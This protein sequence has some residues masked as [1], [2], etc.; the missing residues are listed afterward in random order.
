MS[1]D[2]DNLDAWLREH[3]DANDDL[4][5]LPRLRELYQSAG[6]PEP[7]EADWDRLRSR[8]HK[9]IGR[10][11]APRPWWA[12]AAASVAAAIVATLLTRSLWNTTEPVPVPETVQQI[13]EPFPV[14]DADDVAIVSMDAHDV[15]ALVVGEPPVGEDL[16]FARPEDI[17]VIHCARCPFSGRLARLEKGDEVPMFVTAVAVEA[18]DHE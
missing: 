18:P 10:V 8:I 1:A 9:S 7:N 17:R 11:R 6:L 5:D 4:A 15:A 14:V 3:P 12:I 2:W 13:D 16:E